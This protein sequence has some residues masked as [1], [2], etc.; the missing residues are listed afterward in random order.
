MINMGIGLNYTNVPKS[1]VNIAETELNKLGYRLIL[2]SR[3]SRHPADTYL[4]MVMG[5]ENN[6][7]IYAVWLLNTSLG[8]LHNGDYELDFKSAL[9]TFVNR[10]N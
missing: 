2:I 5:R 1:I 4:W 8:G 9:A 3:F 6:R 7:E 10:L